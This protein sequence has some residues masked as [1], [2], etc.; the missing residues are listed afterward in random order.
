M[1]T[2]TKTSLGCPS[3]G[4]EALVQVNMVLAGVESSFTSCSLCEWRGWERD[5]QHL[6]LASVLTL[7]SPR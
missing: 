2:M 6:P 7:V 1:A 3:C 4:A 5:G